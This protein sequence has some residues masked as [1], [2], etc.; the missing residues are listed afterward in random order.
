MSQ[1]I[2]KR[3]A[4]VN[5][6]IICTSFLLVVIAILLWRN[7]WNRR[8][9]NQLLDQKVKERTFQLETNKY[10][11]QRAWLERDIVVTSA[12]AEIQSAIAT[13]RGLSHVGA[14]EIDQT[15]TADYWRQLD[16]T[17]NRLSAV[18]KRLNFSLETT[19]SKE[20]V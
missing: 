18:L 19:G 1:E 12:T 4:I 16:T 20:L 7:N 2:I 11:L 14:K 9:A 15:R 6:S 8:K 17:S 5:L 3:Q 10:A 13:L